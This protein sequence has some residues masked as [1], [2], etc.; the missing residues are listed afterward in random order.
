MDLLFT[1]A[2]LK[3][4]NEIDDKHLPLL[5]Y[6]SDHNALIAEMVTHATNSLEIELTNRK[7]NFI[8]KNANWHSFANYLNQHC[9][10]EI[11]TDSNL[12][13]EEIDSKIIQLEQLIH[14]AMEKNIPKSK[15]KNS[16]ESYINPKI[17]KLQKY[18]SFLLR[19]INTYY[20]NW[21]N[22]DTEDFRQLKRLLADVKN[23]LKQEFKKS[24]DKYWK[25]KIK[26]IP[27]NDSLNM[28][29]QINQIF[30][31]K[32][33]SALPNEIKIHKDKIQIVKEA[34]INPQTADKDENDN[35]VISD[36]KE[37]LN[38]LGAH[39][40]S[41]QLQNKDMGKPFFTSITERD[42]NLLKQE[43]ETKKKQKK[44]YIP[45][46]D[47]ITHSTLPGKK[48]ISSQMKIR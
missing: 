44:P 12:T 40:A 39:F 8:Y 45:F 9:N 33:I 31:K 26:N 7:S 18:K 17:K 5:D 13:N 14:T 48:I 24:I 10:I 35:F 46:Q 4:L 6:D 34:K 16:V 3:M 22:R 27:L 47:K 28:F 30:R 19:E 37:K 43:M 32:N 25:E 41:I 15:P 38:L 29:P 21:I 23:Q 2:R 1:D 11:S 20:R 36:N 42:T